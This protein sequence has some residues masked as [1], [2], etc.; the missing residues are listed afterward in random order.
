VSVIGEEFLDKATVIP[1]ELTV[2]ASSGYGFV[3]AAVAVGGEVVTAGNLAIRQLGDWGERKVAG[4]LGC[5][6]AGGKVAG[7]GKKRGMAARL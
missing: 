6:G 1:I 3:R 2:L 4:T 7:E 5:R